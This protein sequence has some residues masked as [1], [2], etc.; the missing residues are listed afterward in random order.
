MGIINVTPDSFSHP[1]VLERKR[2]DK[3]DDPEWNT[4]EGCPQKC[5]DEALQ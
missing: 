5:I 1:S 4:N 3:R 2:E